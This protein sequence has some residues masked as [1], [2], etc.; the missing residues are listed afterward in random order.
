MRYS[1]DPCM[2]PLGEMTT[3]NDLAFGIISLLN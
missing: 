3:L 1:G 2:G